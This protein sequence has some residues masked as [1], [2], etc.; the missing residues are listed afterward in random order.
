MRSMS[1]A[2][3]PPPAEEDPLLLALQKALQALLRKAQNTY[4]LTETASEVDAFCGC[5]EAVLQHKFKSKQFY[6]FTVHPWSLVE[7]SESWGDAEAEAVQLAKGVGSSD[8]ARLRA[9]IFVQLNQRSL[10][11]SLTAILEDEALR[12]TFFHEAALMNRPDC[13]QLLLDLLRPL[14]GLSF[15]LGAAAGLASVAVL[16]TV[17]TNRTMPAFF[18]LAKLKS[19]TIVSA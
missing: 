12:Q 3:A 19:A 15:R 11:P 10:Q 14:G 9:W 4:N 2:A 7:A 13:R 8:A 16:A 5:L 1:R 17:V 6:M 18:S